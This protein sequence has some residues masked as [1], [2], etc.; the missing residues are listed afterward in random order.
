LPESMSDQSS[1]Q[2]LKSC[3]IS[4]YRRLR[5]SNISEK[6]LMIRA[7]EICC[8]QNQSRVLTS[9][10]IQVLSEEKCTRSIQGTWEF[11]CLGIAGEGK[12]TR[13]HEK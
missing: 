13:G 3:R 10:T 11:D 8:L 6:G 4:G 1:F 9:S 5:D 12:R 2:R 7:V